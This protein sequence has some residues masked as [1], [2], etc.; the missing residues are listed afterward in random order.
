MQIGGWKIV[1][2]NSIVAIVVNVFFNRKVRKGLTQSSQRKLLHEVVM[3][4]REE[5]NFKIINRK[6]IHYA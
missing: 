6:N 2:S 1:N 3:K 5:E 4:N